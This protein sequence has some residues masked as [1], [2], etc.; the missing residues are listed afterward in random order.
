MKKAGLIS[1]YKNANLYNFKDQCSA[2]FHK[3]FSYILK[4]KLYFIHIYIYKYI[5]R[6]I[7]VCIHKDIYA[8]CFDFF[9]FHSHSVLYNY[10]KNVKCSSVK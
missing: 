9:I 10:Q 3:E 7:D 2:N 6:Y 8:L 5:H 1:S 4:K